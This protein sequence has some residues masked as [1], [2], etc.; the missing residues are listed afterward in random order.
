MAVSDAWV[1]KLNSIGDFQWQKCMGGSGGESANF[2]K[3]TPDG[4]YI[5][6]GAGGFNDGDVSGNHGGA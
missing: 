3:S 5:V 6:A 1:F 4:G 2:I